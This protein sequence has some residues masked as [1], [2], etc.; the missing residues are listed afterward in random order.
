[1]GEFPKLVKRR[2]RVK[3]YEIKINRKSNAKTSQE[4]SRRVP[5]Q[6]QEQV[7]KE[8]EELTESHLERVEKFQDDVFIHPSVINVKK[9]KSVKIA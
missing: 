5:I 4:K 6:L 9:D 1:M 3:N 8:I 2:G 7:D